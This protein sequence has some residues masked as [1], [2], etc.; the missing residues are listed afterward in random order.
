MK[1]SATLDGTEVPPYR[2]NTQKPP[3]W[4]V[5]DAEDLGGGGFTTYVSLQQHFRLLGGG[6]EHLGRGSPFISHPIEMRGHPHSLP[7]RQSIHWGPCTVSR[8][9]FVPTSRAVTQTLAAPICHL[10]E[11]TR[12]S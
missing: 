7:R 5:R 1:V 6:V 2:S 3:Y 11:G 4:D 12:G 10:L 8:S 9:P